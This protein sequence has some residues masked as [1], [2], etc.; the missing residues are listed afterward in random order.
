MSATTVVSTNPSHTNDGRSVRVIAVGASAGGLDA[1]TQLLG[2][3]PA[4]SGLAYVLVQHLDPAHES[5]LAELLARATIIPVMQATDGLRIEAD[6]AY[7]IP[8]G[9]QMTL[10]DG[11]LKLAPRE[12]IIGPA[13]SIDVFF[14]SVADVHGSDAVG[15]VLSGTGSDGALG[16]E[17]IKA[18][19]STAH[20]RG[21][22]MARVSASRSAAALL[23]RWEAI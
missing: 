6:H 14:R 13:R 8:P 2:R 16:L 23:A 10:A 7:V 1:L 21:R 19:G 4:D 9:A 20:S 15:V 18:A 22:L 5:I 3:L 11:H 17:A 12:R